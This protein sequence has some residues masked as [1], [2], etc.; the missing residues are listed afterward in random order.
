MTLYETYKANLNK[1]R[2]LHPDAL[3][4]FVTRRGN[5]ILSPSRGLLND[6]KEKRIDWKTF[7]ERFLREMD[8]DTCRAEMRKIGELAQTKDVFLVCYEKPPKN[9]H[10]YLLMDLIQKMFPDL[11]V[12]RATEGTEELKDVPASEIEALFE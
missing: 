4:I 7:T 8:N 2:D 12:I 11:K 6:Y 5:Y 1:A 3:F 10:R 9:C